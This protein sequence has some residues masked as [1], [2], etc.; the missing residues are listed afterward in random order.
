MSRSDEYTYVPTLQDGLQRVQMAD[1]TASNPT[2]PLPSPRVAAPEESEAMAGDRKETLRKRTGGLS[3]ADLVART[4]A[5]K[6]RYA[7]SLASVTALFMI[8]GDC[9]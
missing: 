3:G 9:F 2:P 5:K 6:P 8:F 4:E 1:G 7:G